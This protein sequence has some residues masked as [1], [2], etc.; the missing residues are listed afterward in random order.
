MKSVVLSPLAY[1][2]I[3][4]HFRT[5]PFRIEYQSNPEYYIISWN[6]SMSQGIQ[7]RWGRDRIITMRHDPWETLPAYCPGTD[8][9]CLE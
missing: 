5:Y 1:S 2:I 7:L 9:E 4:P 8:P 6:Y 3:V